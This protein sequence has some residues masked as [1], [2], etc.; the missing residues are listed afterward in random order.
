[1]ED[2][3]AHLEPGARLD[4]H[5]LKLLVPDIA[6]RRVFISGSPGSVGSLKRAARQAGARR[7]QVDS[8]AGY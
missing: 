6:G 4:G 5:T 1:M 3:G 8:F 2:A 7:I